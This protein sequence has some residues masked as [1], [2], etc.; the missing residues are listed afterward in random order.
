MCRPC[1][2]HQV[3]RTFVLARL[4]TTTPSNWVRMSGGQ[5]VSGHSTTMRATM[6]STFPGLRGPG[7]HRSR[8]SSGGPVGDNGGWPVVGSVVLDNW[9]AAGDWS[10]PVATPSFPA[11]LR[12]H[13]PQTPAP[14]DPAPLRPHPPQT[15][16]P[17]PS[18]VFRR[19]AVLPSVLLTY[20]C[21][22]WV[23]GAHNHN[24]TTIQ[25]RHIAH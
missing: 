6:T 10:E 22:W 9:M 23:P 16:P 14:S 15:R 5:C 11:P 21:A 13:P 18:L 8:P 3:E 4:P 17:S 7:R 20:P 25:T 19:L 2:Q 12:P 1:R 24:P